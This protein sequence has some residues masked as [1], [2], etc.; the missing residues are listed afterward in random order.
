MA[1]FTWCRVPCSSLAG[2]KDS[3]IVAGVAEVDDADD[4]RAAAVTT[5]TMVRRRVCRSADRSGSVLRSELESEIES[6]ATT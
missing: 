4:Y 1:C 3:K 6:C 5:N 2:K